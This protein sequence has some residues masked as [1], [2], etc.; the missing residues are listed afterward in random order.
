MEEAGT[1]GGMYSFNLEYKQKSLQGYICTSILTA[2]QSRQL[3]TVPENQGKPRA[4]LSP[5]MEN[6]S[7]AI[8]NHTWA[9]RRKHHPTKVIS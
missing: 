8:L 1:Y 3:S 4:F 2:T 7:T 9:V 5:H 6:V